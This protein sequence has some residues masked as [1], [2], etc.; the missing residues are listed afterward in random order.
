MTHPVFGINL[1]K[2]IGKLDIA[3]AQGAPALARDCG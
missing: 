2:D 1:L 3:D